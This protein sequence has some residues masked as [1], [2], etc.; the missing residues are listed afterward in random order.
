M[1]THNFRQS[2]A[3]AKR[4]EDAPWWENVYREAFPSMLRMEYEYDALAQRRGIDRRI[5][6]K[7]GKQYVID[8]KVRGKDYSDILL[9]YWSDYEHRIRGWA[10]KDLD[11]DF[12]AYAFFWMWRR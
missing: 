5:Y 2:M 11:C 3:W 7:S 8:E 9:E 10:V 6:L 1:T 12:I 4:Y